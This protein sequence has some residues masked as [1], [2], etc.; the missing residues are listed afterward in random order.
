MAA[1]PNTAQLTT[2]DPPAEDPLYE[3][4]AWG[5]LNAGFA[6]LYKTG[7]NTATGDGQRWS[8]WVKEAFFGN[9]EVWAC[10]GGGQLGAALEDW[11]VGL[12]TEIGTNEYDGYEVIVGGSLSK[13]LIVRRYTNGG[14]TQI[15]GLGSV[16]Y[17]PL[18]GMSL[19]PSNV[20]VWIDTGAGWPPTPTLSIADNT[21]RGA[22]YAGIGLEDPTSGGLYFS[23]FG[24]G[25]PNRPQ[26]FRWLYN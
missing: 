18:I 25:Q 5:P 20:N 12:F 8:I 6:Q 19:T 9:A 15:G 26:F 14:F 17:P 1:F 2:F 13:D 24:G 21:Y 23:C 22:M 4:G 16:G 3:D 7:S 10:A 11:R